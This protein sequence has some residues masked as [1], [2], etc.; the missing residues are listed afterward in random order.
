MG[1]KAGG[2]MMREVLK[3]IAEI[4][5]AIQNSANP[6]QLIKVIKEAIEDFNGKK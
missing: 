4:A 3:A 2:H 1:N 6:W 5:T